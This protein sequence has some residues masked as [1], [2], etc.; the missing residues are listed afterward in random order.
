MSRLLFFAACLVAATAHAEPVREA[1][2]AGNAA[3]VAAFDARDATA[4]AALYSGDARVVAPA[5]PP[6]SGRAAIAEFWAGAM[7]DVKKVQLETLALESAGDLALEDGVV[8][9]TANDGSESAA[10]YL[11]VWK[12]I[13]GHWHL[14]RDIWNGGPPAPEPR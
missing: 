7:Q 4:L 2:D 5:A 1:I 3:F 13:D 9:L 14:H 8:R 6:V 11:V 10:R 12:R